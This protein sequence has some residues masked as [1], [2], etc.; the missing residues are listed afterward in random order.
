M[1]ETESVKESDL[2]HR[3]KNHL[4]IIVGFCEL[5]LADAAGDERRLADLQDIRKAAQ[6]AINMMPEV[7]SRLR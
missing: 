7:A 4:C 3:L 5:L 2:I 1:A 6:D